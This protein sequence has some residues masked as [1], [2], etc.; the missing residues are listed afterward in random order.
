MCSDGA[1]GGRDLD[2][3]VAV[4]RAEQRTAAERLGIADLEWL[5]HADGALSPGDPLLGAL[6]RAIRRVRPELLLGHDPRT[7]WTP[8]GGIAQP[9]HSDHRAAGQATLDAVYPRAASANFYRDQ[10]EGG[11]EAIPDFEATRLSD[12]GLVPW[13]PR[14]LWLFDTAA[15]D[16]RI[17]VGDGFARKLEVLRAH[18]SQEQ[19][20]G[21]LVAAAEA[22]G[23]ALGPRPSDRPRRS[24]GCG[25]TE[26]AQAAPAPRRGRRSRWQRRSASR[27]RNGHDARELAEEQPPH[28]A[29][30]AIC[31]YERPIARPAGSSARPRVSHTCPIWAS[32]PMPASSDPLAAA[33]PHA[34]GEG[35]RAARPVPPPAGTTARS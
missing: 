26:R 18:A 21:G 4:R 12:G 27:A 9:G 13:Y 33:R 30:K 3:P 32:R 6:V 1:R 14:E 2:D 22:L 7:L 10:L 15:P 24:C 8:V 20:A 23:A 5:G 16:L 17:D 34:V 19:A 35:R 28:S 11:L 31:R 25:S 29:A